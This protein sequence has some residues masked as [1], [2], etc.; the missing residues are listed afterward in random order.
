MIFEDLRELDKGTK[1]YAVCLTFI[2]TQDENR[3]LETYVNSYK[4]SVNE[5]ELFDYFGIHG[6]GGNPNGNMIWQLYDALNDEMPTAYSPLPS[7]Y[8]E[9]VIRIIDHREGDEGFC[10]YK[11][12]HNGKKADGENKLRSA[13]NQAKTILLRPSLYDTLGSDPTI[14][15]YY[16]QENEVDDITI[17]SN[18]HK[19][20]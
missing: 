11:A 7:I 1:Y 13:K 6:M 8:E 9:T 17:I 2:D 14:S 5:Q 4:F 3:R 19:V 20:H 18:L 12:Q 16:R 15:F 10:C